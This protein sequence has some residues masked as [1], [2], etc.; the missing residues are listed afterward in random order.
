MSAVVGGPTFLADLLAAVAGS[1]QKPLVRLTQQTAQSLASNTDVALT[2]GAS[3]EEIDTNGFHDTATNTSR[4][5]PTVAGYYRLT[6]TV[7]LAADTDLVS[8]QAAIG[9]NGSIFAPRGLAVLPATATAS[10]PRSAF[11]SLILSAN[12]TT[13]YFELFGRQL[14]TAAT[15]SLTSVGSSSASVFECELLRYL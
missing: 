2:F 7:T 13:D 15:T 14:Q 10:V 3:S 6:G 1:T 4:I 11:V 5:T 8:W 9:K 12:G